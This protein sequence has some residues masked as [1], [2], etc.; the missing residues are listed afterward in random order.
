MERKTIEAVKQ[1]EALNSKNTLRVVLSIRS[2]S[3][4]PDQISVRLGLDP[5][6]TSEKGECLYKGKSGELYAV[7]CS[8]RLESTGKID[9]V[10]LASHLNWLVNDQLSGREEAIRKLSDDD[11]SIELICYANQWTRLGYF[12]ISPDMIASISQLGLRLK[13]QIMYENTDSEY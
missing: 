4:T 1:L 5:S 9:D 3:L 7:S 13:F 12:E 8:W 10:L 11:C 2:G 6:S